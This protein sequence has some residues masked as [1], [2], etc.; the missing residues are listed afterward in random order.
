M[1]GFFTAEA[2]GTPFSRLLKA[3]GLFLTLTP[4]ASFPVLQALTQGSLPRPLTENPKTA[5]IHLHASLFSLVIHLPPCGQSNLSRMWK[6]AS[7]CPYQTLGL[8]DRVPTL[9]LP[10][11][12]GSA[13][14][15]LY[16]WDVTPLCHLAGHSS[17]AC[18]SAC[19]PSCPS[20]SQ[21][22]VSISGGETAGPGW[23]QGLLL[24]PAAEIPAD[25]E[26]PLPVS[27]KYPVSPLPSS[28]WRG[29]AP[30][31][32]VTP[33]LLFQSWGGQRPPGL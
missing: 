11:Q 32:W 27:K 13:A 1:G 21:G 31:L 25:S 9:S 10:S 18:P 4:I 17:G 24:S 22:A 23:T 6:P 29:A 12:C 28:P 19:L 33:S 7:I 16:S 8:Q 2:P 30:C 14:V 26:R 20:C 15:R 3:D 5:P